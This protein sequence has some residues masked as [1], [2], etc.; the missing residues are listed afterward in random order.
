[1][2]NFKCFIVL[3]FIKNSFFLRHS[4]FSNKIVDVLNTKRGH[5]DEK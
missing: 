5:V 4:L 2:E 3:I 1:M